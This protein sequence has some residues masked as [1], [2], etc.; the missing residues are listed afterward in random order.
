MDH[1]RVLKKVKHIR[2]K[3][4]PQEFFIQIQ[5]KTIAFHTTFSI[6]KNLTYMEQML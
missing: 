3:T 4:Q 5:S 1:Q 2:E 6:S